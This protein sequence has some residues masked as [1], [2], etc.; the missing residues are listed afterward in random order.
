MT[1]VQKT[2]WN[3]SKKATA[4]VKDPV[5]MPTECNCC[6]SDA[7][8]YATHIEVYGRDYSDWPYV[9]LCEGCGAYVGLHP[10][11]GIPLGTLADIETRE[12]RKYA[13]NAFT[14]VVE[15]HMANRSAA[16]AW[17]AEAMGI[18]PRLCHFGMFDVDQ[19]HRARGICIAL[20]NSK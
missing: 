10:F 3:P 1:P 5:P 4:R 19:A 18:E 20:I 8:R 9:C 15:H 7:V 2:P 16:Y 17:L 14:N 13:K 6:G 11:T 12:A